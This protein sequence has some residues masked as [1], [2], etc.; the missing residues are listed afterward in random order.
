MTLFEAM[1][2]TGVK[3]PRR[4]NQNIRCPFH[5]DRNASLSVDLDSDRWKCFGCGEGGGPKKWLELSGAPEQSTSQKHQYVWRDIEGNAV[6]QT[7]VDHA[8][9]SKAMLLAEGYKEHPRS[10]P[11]SESR[12]PGSGRRGYSSFR[13]GCKISRSHRQGGV[14]R[15]GDCGRDLN[16]LQRALAGVARR[17]TK[18][19]YMGAMA[20][21]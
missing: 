16:T 4:T 12:D 10:T 14:L 1:N 19:R 3:P 6:T 11:P 15:S 20:G 5:D 13:R 8:D 21:Q 2:K 18:A 17:H 7:R 9:G